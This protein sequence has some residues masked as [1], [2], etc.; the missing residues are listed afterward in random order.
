M[1]GKRNKTTWTENGKSIVYPV[2]M[3]EKNYNIPTNQMVHV[4]VDNE[5]HCFLE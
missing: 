3:L 1:Y 5:L 2:S 4:H